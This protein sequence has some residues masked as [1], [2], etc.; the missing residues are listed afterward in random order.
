MSGE[1]YP[2]KCL[3]FIIHIVYVTVPIMLLTAEGKVLKTSL[4]PKMLEQV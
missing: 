4:A 1:S 3:F 2:S